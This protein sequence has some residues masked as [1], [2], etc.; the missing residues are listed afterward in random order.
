KPIEDLQDRIQIGNCN[1]PPCRFRKD[2]VVQAEFKF[3][4]GNCTWS[5][6]LIL[7]YEYFNPGKPKCL[8]LVATDA[9]SSPEEEE[10]LEGGG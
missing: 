10:Q 2:T 6:V 3:K 5:V 8:P 4:P 1:K 9:Y 7:M